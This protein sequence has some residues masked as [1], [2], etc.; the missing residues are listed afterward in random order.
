[1]NRVFKLV[2]LG[3]LVFAM[4]TAPALADAFNVTL[5][6]SPLSGPLKLVFQLNDG[7]GVNDNTV[8]LSAF[9]FDGGSAIGSGDCSL[10]GNLCSGDL[11]SSV[12]LTDVDFSVI[13]DQSFN[14]GSSL[15]FTLTLSN[16][17]AGGGTPDAFAMSLCSLDFSACFSDD[18]SSGALL[19]VNLNGGGPLSPADFILNGASAQNLDAPVVTS[20]GSTAVPEPATL[21]LLCTGMAGALLRRKRI[22]Y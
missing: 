2:I 14:P 3:G 1:M 15:S 10:G 20:L 5:N 7:D 19:A 11:S 8:T 4:E 21:L 6:T 18:Q 16:N 13:L 17:F 9:N 12:S 22:N